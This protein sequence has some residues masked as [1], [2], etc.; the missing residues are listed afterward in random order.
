MYNIAHIYIY[1]LC[2]FVCMSV[3]VHGQSNRCWTVIAMDFN[4]N[5]AELPTGGWHK[6]LNCKVWEHGMASSVT[7]A[8]SHDKGG[9]GRSVTGVHGSVTGVQNKSVTGLHWGH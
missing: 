8:E 6:L 5:W 7:E 4:A 2:A 9:G 3:P 1:V